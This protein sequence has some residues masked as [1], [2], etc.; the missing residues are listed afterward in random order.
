LKIKNIYLIDVPVAIMKES[1]VGIH[2]RYPEP[3][4]QKN[5]LRLAEETD[6]LGFD[7]IYVAD[8]L[9][10]ILEPMEALSFIAARTTLSRQGTCIYLLPL[11]SPYHVAKQVATI[12]RLAERRFT[13]GVGVGWRRGEFE[14]LGVDWEK[15]GKI[16]DEALQVLN[17]AWSKDIFSFKG[18]FFS[19]E[20]LDLNCRLEQKP[21]ILIGG[22]S[23]SA[24]RRAAKY[25][26]G[27]VPTDFSVQDYGNSIREMHNELRSAGREINSFKFAS[28][29]LIIL[30]RDSKSS[31]EMASLVAKDFGVNTEEMKDWSLIGTPEEVSERIASY[32][33]EGVNYHILALPSSIS[34]EEQVE[35][36]RLLAEE[37]IPSV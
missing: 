1:S 31:N 24:M 8:Q 6:R 11:R 20:Q 30:G 36:L 9:A 28:H 10:S 12:Q 22:N 19:A 3:F 15:R 33:S 7:C 4:N 18:D 26:D 35:S 25:G 2:L 21:E 14:V 29:L 32:N 27:W 16:A 37:V 34:I 17:L 13:L 5:L 23:R